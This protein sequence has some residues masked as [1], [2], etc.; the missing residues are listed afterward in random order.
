MIAVSRRT[1]VI[2]AVVVL[3]AATGAGVVVYR[4]KD[5]TASAAAP[6]TSVPASA[7]ASSTSPSRPTRTSRPTS[8]PTSTSAGDELSGGLP[9]DLLPHAVEDEC[10][11]TGAE[12]EVLTGRESLRAENTE[13]AGDGRRSCFYGPADPNSDDGPAGRVDVYSSASLPPPD[14]VSRIAATAAGSKPLTGV[15]SGAVV[16]TGASGRSE[17]VVASP[18]LLIVLTLLPGGAATPPSDEAWAAAGATMVGRLPA[19]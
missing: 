11:L 10:L 1:A 18:N 19:A 12:F 7:A 2:V 14:L 3:A 5:P 6:T 17:L 15:G 13:L 8:T 4:L 16:V 9:G